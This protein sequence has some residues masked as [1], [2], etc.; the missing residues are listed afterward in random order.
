MN[1]IMLL[2]VVAIVIPG[3]FIVK[4]LSRIMYTGDSKLDQKTE[5]RY[6][7]DRKEKQRVEKEKQKENENISE[8]VDVHLNENKTEIPEDKE[9]ITS[10][11]VKKES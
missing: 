8:N 6:G 5:S 3:Y 2:I 7:F 9:N 4:R 10:E 1:I 11:G